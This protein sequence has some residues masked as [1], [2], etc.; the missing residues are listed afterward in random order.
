MS[1]IGP[2][3]FGSLPQVNPY[4]GNVR[5]SGDSDESRI[6]AADRAVD[7]DHNQISSELNEATEPGKSSDRDADGFYSSGGTSDGEQS[8]PEDEA[9]DSSSAGT[10]TPSAS[11]KA[12]P[13]DD[14]R[15]TLIDFEA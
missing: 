4:A 3:G 5:G 9:E 1:S 15:G 14:H 6:N 7:G 8:A 11:D 10:G 13:N 12:K 2:S